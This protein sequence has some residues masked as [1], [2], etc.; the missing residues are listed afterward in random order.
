MRKFKLLKDY[1]N[2]NFNTIKKGE[3]NTEKQ[4]CMIFPG[5]SIPNSKNDWFEEVFEKEFTRKDMI[6]FGE[7]CVK[8]MNFPSP[9]LITETLSAFIAER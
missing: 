1:Q 3:I 9:G 2:P 6:K 8:S 4:W 5:L 7:E